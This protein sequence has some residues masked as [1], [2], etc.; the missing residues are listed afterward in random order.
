MK[1]KDLNDIDWLALS[2]KGGRTIVSG[3]SNCCLFLL[4]LFWL[5]FSGLEK[6]N[7]GSDSVLGK[8]V[9]QFRFLVWLDFSLPPCFIYTNGVLLHECGQ[10]NKIK[11]AMLG[12]PPQDGWF[13]PAYF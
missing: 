12:N 3:S 13:G 11:K 6:K 7:N 4:V 1:E 9:V 8:I 5:G 2:T 10:P